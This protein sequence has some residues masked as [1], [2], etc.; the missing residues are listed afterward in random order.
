V[1]WENKRED[2]IMQTTMPDASQLA[3]LIFYAIAI[4]L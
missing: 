4:S 1:G 3:L 2:I